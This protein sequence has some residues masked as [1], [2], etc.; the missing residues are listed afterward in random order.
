MAAIASEK[1]IHST[2]AYGRRGPSC[3]SVRAFNDATRNRTAMLLRNSVRVVSA[4]HP[5][6]ARHYKWILAWEHCL[7]I[8]NRLYTIDRIFVG[9]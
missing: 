5:D 6:N 9:T 1:N 7:K 2:S 3:L 8:Y 4:I